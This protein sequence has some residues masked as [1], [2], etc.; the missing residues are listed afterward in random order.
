MLS[1]SSQY[2]LVACFCIYYY[3]D[4]LI[5]I[6]DLNFGNISFDGKLYEDVL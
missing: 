6:T 2:V 1:F 4:Y 3:L 5:N